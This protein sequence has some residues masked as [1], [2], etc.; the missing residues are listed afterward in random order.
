L[1]R[2][3]W[4]SLQLEEYVER[5]LGFCQVTRVP[6]AALI[7]GALFGMIEICA[8]A[9]DSQ[10]QEWKEQSTPR[11]W[12]EFRS[13]LRDIREDT[14]WAKATQRLRSAVRFFRNSVMAAT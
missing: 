11:A 6:N 2:V 3:Q 4:L 7:D 13:S 12:Q 10:I 1:Q 8:E 9:V 5:W 14:D